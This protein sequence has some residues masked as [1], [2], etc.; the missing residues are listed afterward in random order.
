MS[1]FLKSKYAIFAAIVVVGIALDQWTKWYASERLA[2]TRPGFIEHP[3]ELTVD[4]DDAGESVQEFL[5]GEFAA[6]TPDEIESIARH[7]VDRP[8]DAPL[9]AGER[10]V[11]DNRSVTVVDGYWEFEYTVNPGAA[12]GLLSDTDSPYRMPFF[13]VV[14]LLAVVVIVY[15]L[16]GVHPDQTLLIVALSLIG[17]GAVGNFIDRVRF[18]HVIDFIVWKYTD[19]FRWPTFNLA[20]AFIT[21]GVVLMLFEIFFGQAAETSSQSATETERDESE[22]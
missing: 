9:E 18:G 15:L 4:E 22:T 7:H 10:L 8:A 3:I 11:V 13:I 6:N 5:A 14:S 17:T 12:F 21:V 1:R 20:D 19:Q 16:R 2:T